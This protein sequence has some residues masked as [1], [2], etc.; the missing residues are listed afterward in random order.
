MLLQL[1]RLGMLGRCELY[2]ICLRCK[3]YGS[4]LIGDIQI[5]AVTL[6]CPTLSKFDISRRSQITM[7]LGVLLDH[8]TEGHPK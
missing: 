8:I 5:D 1:V 3:A 4:C 6:L 7:L 2:V